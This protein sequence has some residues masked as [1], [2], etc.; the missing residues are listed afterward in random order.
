MKN[1][2]IYNLKLVSKKPFVLLRV[3]KNYYLLLRGQKRLR[4][5]E[6]DLG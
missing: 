5:V 1:R 2:F 4:S 3:L 6:I